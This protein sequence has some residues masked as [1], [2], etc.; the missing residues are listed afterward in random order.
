MRTAALVLAVCSVVSAQEAIPPGKPWEQWFP[1]TVT[2]PDPNSFALYEEAFRLIEQ[3]GEPEE[4][5]ELDALAR[6]LEDHAAALALIHAAIAGEC[7]LPAATSLAQRLP[8]LA[9]F[10]SAARVLAARARVMRDYGY[11]LES[12]LDCID[13]LHMAQDVATQRILISCLVGRAIERIMLEQLH[14]TIPALTE[15]EAVLC[16]N[17]MRSALRRRLPLRGTLEGEREAM[18]WAFR[19]E[20]VPNLGD[21]AKLKELLGG[22]GGVTIP[23]VW[24]PARA[25][26]D[27]GTQ[28]DAALANAE[29]PVWEPFAR[30]PDADPMVLL[31]LPVMTGTLLGE[32]DQLA[33]LR[34]TLVHLAVQAAWCRDG[35]PPESLDE[36]VPDYLPEVPTDPFNDEPMRWA[37]RDD[38]WYVYSVGPDLQDDG[39]KSLGD[40]AAAES[41]GD[42]S[43]AVDT[44]DSR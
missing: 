38:V 28:F 22:D 15:Q 11:Y 4:G 8:Y 32:R 16:I 7:R 30:K 33:R 25:W 34:G 23:P 31:L 44:P 12:A 42:V 29:V 26:Q 10:R 39:G 14:Q 41:V 13:G 36:L 40:R 19:D 9:Q 5:L 24:S 18:R 27:L 3:V 43:V 1:T 37:A 35:T 2:L 20:L 21:P 6:V 17:H